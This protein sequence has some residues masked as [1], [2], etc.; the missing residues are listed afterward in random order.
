MLSKTERTNTHVF[1]LE[2]LFVFVFFFFFLGFSLL[3]EHDVISLFDLFDKALNMR[4]ENIL[5]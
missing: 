1:Y 2:L 3:I 5:L 4:N